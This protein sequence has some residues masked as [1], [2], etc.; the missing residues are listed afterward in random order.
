MNMRIYEPGYDIILLGNHAWTNIGLAGIYQVDTVKN[1]GISLHSSCTTLLQRDGIKIGA[2][3]YIPDGIDRMRNDPAFSPAVGGWEIAYSQGDIHLVTAQGTVYLIVDELT[4]K[5][6]V[7]TIAQYAFN[8]DPL[9][10]QHIHIE[11]FPPPEF[12]GSSIGQDHVRKCSIVEEINDVT[13]A[14]RLVG[15]HMIDHLDSTFFP[16]DRGIG[17][18]CFV[19]SFIA[20]VQGQLLCGLPLQALIIDG[21]GLAYAPQPVVESI[22]LVRRGQVV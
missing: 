22:V 6:I 19:E 18:V 15:S 20:H 7:T 2:H 16:I 5:C 11:Q 8:P 21:R 13:D 10:L 9:L 4:V 17:N 14:V 1:Q 12:A 3:V